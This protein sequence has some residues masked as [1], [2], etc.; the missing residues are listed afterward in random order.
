V[1][2]DRTDLRSDLFALGVIMY[3]L[4]TGERPFGEPQS[5]GEWKR[6]LWRDPFPPRRWKEDIPPWLQEIIMRCLEVDP[7]ARYAS[8]AQLAFALQHPEQVALTERATRTA[9]DGFLAVAL[10]HYRATGLRSVRRKSVSGILSGAPIIMVAVDL[11]TGSEALAEALRVAVRRIFVTEPS[12]RVACVN[13]LKLSRLAPDVFETEEGRNLHLQ[14]LIELKDWARTLHIEEGRLTYHVF[15][16]SDPAAAIVD[17]ARNNH[18]DH[19][20]VGARANSALRRYLGSVSSHVVA[21]APCTV[22]VVRT[23]DAPAAAEA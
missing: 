4:A 18:V 15:E 10:R 13:V 17:Y 3:F 16:S 19:I 14:C 6:R 7:N 22:T 20:V 21:E 9:R 5:A 12:A 2:R 1:L 11:A 8:A 23:S